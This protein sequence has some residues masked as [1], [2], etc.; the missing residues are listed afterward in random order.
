MFRRKGADEINHEDQVTLAPFLG[1]VLDSR[2]LL[3]PIGDRPQALFADLLVLTP[4]WSSI[5][6]SSAEPRV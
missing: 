2:E 5:A 6:R 4:Y 1:A 3:A